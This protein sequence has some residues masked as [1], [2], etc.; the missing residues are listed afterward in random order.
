MGDLKRVHATLCDHVSAINFNT[1]RQ[2]ST[3]NLSGDRCVSTCMLA[4]ADAACVLKAPGISETAVQ[5]TSH[6]VGSSGYPEKS[7]SLLD[8]KFDVHWSAIDHRRTHF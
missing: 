4:T 5:E 8:G 2:G 1:L 3:R 6:G 7:T